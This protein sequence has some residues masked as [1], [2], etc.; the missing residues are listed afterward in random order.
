MAGRRPTPNA[1]TRTVKRLAAA[2]EPPARGVL[3]RA[4]SDSVAVSAGLVAG[5]ALMIAADAH[6]EGRTA[7]AVQ[8][9]VVLALTTVLAVAARRLRA[10]AE[11]AA[12]IGAGL[13]Q[14]GEAVL[15]TDRQTLEVVHASPA[16]ASVYARPVAEIVGA[17]ARGFALAEDRALVEE[18]RRLRAAGH[19]LPGRITLPL[20]HPGEGDRYVE[21]SSVPLVLG[22]HELL[23]HVAHDATPRVAA[24]RSLAEE[25]RF[26]EAVFD[27]AAHPIVV[28][29]RDGTLLRVN[30]AA[31]RLAGRDAGA[32]T[33]STPWELGLISRAEADTVVAALA[34]GRDPHHHVVTWRTPA[35]E[36]KVVAWAA[37]TMRDADGTIRA[38]VTVGRDL[39][40]QRAAEDRARRAHAALDLRSHELA[41]TNHD[42][43]Q[44][45]TLA[46]GDLRDPVRAVAGFADLLDAHA[47]ATLDARGHSY[48]EA[49]REAAG[50]AGE[51]LDGLALYARL[52]HGEALAADVDCERTLDAVLRGLAEEIAVRDAVVTRDPLPTVPGD[53]EELRLLLE[54]L[55]ANAVR[56][57]GAERPRVHVGAERRGLGWQLTVADDGLG[58]PETERQRI[59]QLFGRLHARGAHRGAGVGLALCRRIAER[60]GGSVWVEDGS[61]GGS[62][63]H[64]A[65]PDR[66]AR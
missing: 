27:A 54:H 18:R 26:M 24:E 15:I 38:A 55:I 10:R 17:D 48:L 9:I 51:M 25:R 61:R 21:W 43:T 2:L 59:F 13:D 41:R 40:G 1:P 56:F 60:H 12:A 4:V 62:V 3:A 57:G 14:L 49:L 5:L 33:G 30:E 63:F 28:L 64:V 36:Q 44:L 8:G 39:T 52:G 31:A 37:T 65:L 45:G 23:L 50:H 11:L 19:K 22:G 35:G 32:M 34:A 29:G 20:A 6:L 7:L 16:A 53:A 66:E 42:L 47:G 46:A 58:V